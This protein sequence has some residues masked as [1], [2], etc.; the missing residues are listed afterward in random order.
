MKRKSLI[1]AIIV[2]ISSFAFSSSPVNQIHAQTDVNI[3]FFIEDAFGE[4]YYINKGIMESY[5]WT[6]TTASSKSF[7]VGCKND[8]KN[9]TDTY[10][11]VLV[12]DIT[13]KDLFDYDCILVP[14]GGHW[15]N[16]MG[17]ARVVEIIQSS[18]EEGILV[19]GIC[20]GMIVLAY[21]DILE[22]VEVAYN[23]HATEWLNYAGANMTGYPVVSDQGIITGGFGGGLGSGPE[24]APNELFCEKIK[25]EIESRTTQVALSSILVLTGIL[26]LCIVSVQ[27]KYAKR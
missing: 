9:V 10:A 3:L 8:G 18:H 11:D 27:R 15:G 5:N 2:I 21:A 13:D 1:I 26:A 6:V 22:E 14:S 25:E 17:V 24:G 4:S 19:A 23:I 20:T 7:I 16:V 12:G